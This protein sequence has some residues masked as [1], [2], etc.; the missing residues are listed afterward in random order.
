M[1]HQDEGTNQGSQ[2]RLRTD[3][4]SPSAPPLATS[5]PPGSISRLVLRAGSLLRAMTS[6][7]LPSR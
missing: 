3:E 4:A 5:A 1:L 7:G 2:A 6:D